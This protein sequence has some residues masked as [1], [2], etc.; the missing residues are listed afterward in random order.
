MYIYIYIERERYCVFVFV[1]Y[2]FL[3]YTYCLCMCV[4]MC[5]Y[6]YI[7]HML[8]SCFW[9]PWRGGRSPRGRSRGRRP[10]RTHRSCS[11]PVRGRKMGK[12]KVNP[13][14]FGKIKAGKQD[15]PKGPSVKKNMKFAGTISADPI[16]PFP[17]C[18]WHRDKR[19]RM[20]TGTYLCSI[21]L[22]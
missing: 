7:L 14:T 17:N 2:V 6:I 4:C 18:H 15:Y 13:G 22:I 21:W 10:R 3:V 16:C 8:V 12:E 11:A 20:P 19:R 5:I 9:R 1:V